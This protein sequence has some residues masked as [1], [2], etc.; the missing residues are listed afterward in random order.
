[1]VNLHSSMPSLSDL[2][3]QLIHLLAQSEYEQAASVC[4][5][6]AETHPDS[7]MGY[8][9]LGLI[10]VL[11]GQEADAQMTWL[12]AIAEGTPDETETWTQELV[13]VLQAEASRREAGN[14]LQ[15]AWV[16]RQHSQEIAPADVNNLLHLIDLSLTLNTF[17]AEYLTTLGI[18][19][20]LQADSPQDI[21]SAL[22]LQVL[23]HLLQDAVQ[24]PPVADLAEACLPYLEKSDALVDLLVATM[25]KL[26]E[27]PR[28][29][30]LAYQYGRLAMQLDGDR[31]DVLYQLCCACQ[32]SHRY[33]E[34][35]ELARRYYDTCQ[36][37]TQKILGNALILRGLMNTGTQWAEAS[38]VLQRQTELLQAL[39]AE[40]DINGDRLADI[41][42]ICAPLFFYPYFNDTPRENRLL[43]NQ[44]V[45][46]YQAGLD[47]Y[48]KQHVTDYQ[49]YPAA[50]L[51]RS[52]DR[53][54]L[55]IGYLS[56]FLYRHSIGWLSR[57]LLQHFDRDRF[58]V[59]VYFVQPQ[60][61]DAF[62]RQ[63]FADK[64]TR[65][66]AFEGDPL[67]IAKSIREDEIDILVD[68]D[69]LTS[70]PT[71]NVMALKPAPIQVTWLGLDASG[72]PTID[73]FLADPYVL[74]DDAQDY[75]AERIW[76]LP[77]T[78]VAV[79]GFEVDVP[80]LRRDQLDIPADAVVY[81]SAQFAYKRH[82]DTVRLQMQILSQVPDSY[83]LV[84]G[85]GDEQSMRELF[86][87]EAAAFGISR[88]RL[89]FLP[90]D[91]NEESHRA[92]LAIADIVLDTFPYN[93]ATT[94]LETLWMG[95]PLVTRVGQQFAAR[96]SYTMMVN[97]GITEGIAWSDEEYVEWGIRLGKDAKL[98]QQVAQKLW[99]SRQTAP[100]WNGKQFTREV[101]HAYEQMWATFM[102][103]R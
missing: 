16:I 22:L 7:R 51:T 90:R 48:L 8:W 94:T 24:Y 58:E 99:Q 20:Q 23:E 42:L 18:T 15:I 96:N 83:F 45:Q 101:E 67:G 50:P 2:E 11:Q 55:R 84:K 17:T 43:Q 13:Q 76:R 92:N 103:A 44:V 36:T 4:E 82:P 1:M 89:R 35:I 30:R 10:H 86:A 78:Y 91:R 25:I 29:G 14:D 73:Y 63:W 80:T 40:Q 98:R 65:A 54:V 53:K 69:S 47:A 77:Q 59:Y 33:S 6:L 74:P 26:R 31:P 97:A 66:C 19:D 75:Y 100:L 49:P 81:L 37:L 12:M 52:P 70:L 93:G 79:D 68:L 38:A 88:D 62:S 5:Y 28:V 87:Q 27:Y 32:D 95:I 64:A 102:A 39:L 57:W 56:Q 21:D 34:G 61:M 3:L 41:S 71:C 46:W 72:L 60:H 9:Y 85:L